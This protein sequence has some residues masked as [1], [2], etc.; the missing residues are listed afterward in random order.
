MVQAVSGEQLR[1]IVDVLHDKWFRSCDALDV[2]QGTV[3]LPFWNKSSD[4]EKTEPPYECV[5]EHVHEV[6][7]IDK[8]RIAYY[9]LND[10]RFLKGSLEFSTGIP[11]ICRF[12]IKQLRVTV[13]TTDR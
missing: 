10:V 6:Q 2:Y 7:L 3:R 8:E 12:R 9:D 1:E 11:L 4:V 5:I 13:T